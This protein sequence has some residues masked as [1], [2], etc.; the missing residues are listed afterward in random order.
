[1]GGC[2]G[3]SGKKKGGEISVTGHRNG[4][5]G[6]EPMKREKTKHKG[7]YKVG[8]NYYIVYYVGNKNV[9]K[10]IGPNLKD[11]LQEKLERE[12]KVR[13]GKYEIIENQEKMTFEDL[14][15]LYEKEGENKP[16]VRLFK[17]RYLDSFGKWKLSQ[18]TRKDLFA[19]RSKVKAAPT[20]RGKKPV[21]DSTINRALA[22]LRRL[23][24]FAVDRQL[25]EDSPFPRNPKSG[26]FYSE[27]KGFRRFFTQEQVVQIFKAC[28]EWLRPIVLTAYYTGMRMGEILKLRW[29]HVSLEIGVINLPSSKTLKDPSGLGQRI[30]MQ[31]KLI[32]IFE[33]IPR[34]SDWVF[35]NQ[36]GLPY[37]PWIVYKPF[38]AALKSVGIDPKLYSFKEL[39]HTTGSIMNLK[40]S[41]PMAIKD[42]LRHTD[43]KTTQDFYIGSD[44][45]Y[46]REQ[47]EK[48][49]LNIPEASA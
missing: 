32:N 4:R 33:V 40:G 13:R 11:A 49:A 8:K 16:Y 45:E 39:R 36:D 10:K 5:T 3:L 18:I 15:S 35:A 24:N 19:F 31:K 34:R 43:F 47:I 1:M 22:G 17:Q 41:D 46:Q 6:D 38:K 25:M 48:I 12:N 14:L 27:K 30:V 23:F 21:T 28:P 44:I 2:P 42:Q 9:E 29:E 26:L 20:Q 7:V 37:P